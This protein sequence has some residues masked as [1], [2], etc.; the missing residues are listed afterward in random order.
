[1]LTCIIHLFYVTC[2]ISCKHVRVCEY[3]ADEFG[4][5]AAELGN[6]VYCTLR[7]QVCMHM[8]YMYI[9]FVYALYT[10]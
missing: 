9:L 1:M 4:K 7:M 2:Y 10:S 5:S 3:R 8:Y 6:A